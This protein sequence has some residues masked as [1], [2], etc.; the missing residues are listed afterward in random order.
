MLWAPSAWYKVGGG[1][2]DVCVFGGATS[3]H[4]AWRCTLVAP[5]LLLT[6]TLYI[7]LLLV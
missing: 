5:K 2:N 1:G 7:S 3:G 4:Q 6:T